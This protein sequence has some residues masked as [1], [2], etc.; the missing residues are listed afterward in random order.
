MLLRMRQLS[1]R[2]KLTPRKRPKTKQML[3]RKLMM[4]PLQRSMLPKKRQMK[5]LRQQNKLKQ[6]LLL[7]QQLLLMNLSSKRLRVVTLSL[8]TK[9][10]RRKIQFLSWRSTQTKLMRLSQ[11][12]IL[13]LAH[14]LTSPQRFSV[15]LFSPRV[16]SHSLGSTFPKKFGINSRMSRIAM[17]SLSIK[18]FS[19]DARTLIQ[20]SVSM[21]AAMIL[22]L[23]LPPYSIRS[24]SNITVTRR[25]TSTAVIW[26]SP[27]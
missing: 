19:P 2:P 20:V 21:L 10:W 8:P 25:A 17:A 27:S 26:T 12:M 5:S 16:P 4:K 15:S 7:Q 24:L 6:S 11:S 18:P 14:T 22:I 13:K 1:L 3:R 9:S 23:H